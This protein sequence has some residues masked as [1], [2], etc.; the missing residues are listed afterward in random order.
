[1]TIRTLVAFLFVLS[2]HVANAQPAPK[3]PQSSASTGAVYDLSVRGTSCKESR[4]AG[5][6][7]CTYRVGKDLEFSIAGIGDPDAGIVFV[8]SN[9]DGDYYAS[10]GL[11]HG[12]V[13]VRHGSAAPSPNDLAF[14]SPRN[15]RVYRT[16]QECRASTREP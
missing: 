7:E 5:G 6:I 3:E 16:W 15:G 1:M 11:Q 10:Y 9:F 13:I 8:R 2:V 14:V 12:C 4:A